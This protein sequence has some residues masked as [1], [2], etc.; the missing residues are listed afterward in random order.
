M[1]HTPNWIED[2]RQLW[3]TTKLIEVESLLNQGASTDASNGDVCVI[4]A[5]TQFYCL[6]ITTHCIEACASLK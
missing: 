5:V 6:L 2:L 3:R 1:R 4:D